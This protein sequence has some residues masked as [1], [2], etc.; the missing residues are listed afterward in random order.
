MSGD[1]HHDHHVYQG[2]PEFMPEI[3]ARYSF[4][5]PSYMAR[6]DRALVSRKAMKP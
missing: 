4:P 1:S 5:D 3:A 6:S 2:A